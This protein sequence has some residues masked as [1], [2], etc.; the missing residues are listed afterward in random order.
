VERGRIWERY[1]CGHLIIAVAKHFKR[2]RFTVSSIINRTK[3]ENRS[4]FLTKP[5]HAPPKKTTDRVDWAFICYVIANLR[6]PLTIL[7]TPSKSGKK[8]GRN[9]IR[10]ILKAY[11]KSKRVLRKKPWLRP[12]N[13]TKRLLW[14]RVEKKR[15][16]N[17]KRYASLIRPLFMSESIT[18][19]F[20]LH[21][22][23][24][25]SG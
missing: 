9:T 4:D 23:R 7:A 10:K 5:R 12:E 22:D 11:G 18:K 14:T 6:C 13:I 15:K 8:L 3:R 17:W 19:S 1:E 21:V 25:R 20:T 16:R 2:P 24:T